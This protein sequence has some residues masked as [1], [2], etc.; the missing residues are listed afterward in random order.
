MDVVDCNGGGDGGGGVAAQGDYAGA[1][2]DTDGGLPIVFKGWGE[3][4]GVAGAAVQLDVGWRLRGFIAG[5][6]SVVG[7]AIGGVEGEDPVAGEAVFPGGV[8]EGGG[9]GLGVALESLAGA[10]DADA[11][12][13]CVGGK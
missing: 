13:V 5:D 11:C 8:H 6:A 12:Y 4:D 1:Y 7:V 10:V 2:Q 3:A 9:A